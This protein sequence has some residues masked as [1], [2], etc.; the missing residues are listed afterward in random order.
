MI[1]EHIVQQRF[2]AKK[3]F[4]DLQNDR[5]QQSEHGLLVGQTQAFITKI[6]KRKEA[7]ED[8]SDYVYSLRKESTMNDNRGGKRWKIE[9]Y[10]PFLN[11]TA[12]SY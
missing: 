4:Y 6:I 5:I 9:L 3:S 2:S 10:S 7:P 12:W 1:K 11:D 8:D